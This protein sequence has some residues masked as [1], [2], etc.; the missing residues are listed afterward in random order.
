[1]QLFSFLL[2]YIKSMQY[3]LKAMCKDMCVFLEFKY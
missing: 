2:Q 1:M 3:V